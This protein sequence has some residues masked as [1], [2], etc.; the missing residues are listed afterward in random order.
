MYPDSVPGAE[1]F[2][3]TSLR[4]VNRFPFP[5]GR[6]TS[7]LLTHRCDD[8]IADVSDM[9]DFRLVTTAVRESVLQ[10]AL[11]AIDLL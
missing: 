2:P 6:V 11:R 8:S 5:H 1:S 4:S 9:P 7:S 3:S 10:N